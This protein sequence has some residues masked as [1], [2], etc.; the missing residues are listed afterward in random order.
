MGTKADKRAR[1]LAAEMSDNFKRNEDME[2]QQ[3]QLD[4]LVLVPVRHA[5]PAEIKVKPRSK[6]GQRKRTWKDGRWSEH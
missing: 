6:R 2:E 4:R 5:W 1:H 3:S